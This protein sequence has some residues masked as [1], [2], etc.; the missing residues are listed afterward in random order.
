[1]PLPSNT[2]DEVGNTANSPCVHNSIAPVHAIACVTGEASRCRNPL[3]L[4]QTSLNEAQLLAAASAAFATI[5]K[6]NANAAGVLMPYGTV[7]TLVCPSFLDSRWGAKSKITH[8]TGPCY[9][10]L[11]YV[12]SQNQVSA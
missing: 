5:L 6:T 9:D 3:Q 7:H 1:M 2:T 8:D 11:H 12:L 10:E 4:L